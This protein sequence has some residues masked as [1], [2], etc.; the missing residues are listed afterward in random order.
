M[1]DIV[2][3]KATSPTK[4][5]NLLYGLIFAI[6]L[7]ASCTSIIQRIQCPKMTETELFFRIPKSF[8]LNFHICK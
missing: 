3:V 2:E 7:W 4:G 5:P 8:V 6:V 1:R